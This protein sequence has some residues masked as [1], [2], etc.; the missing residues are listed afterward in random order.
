MRTE[1]AADTFSSD[2]IRR[3]RDIRETYES[4]SQS[5]PKKEDYDEKVG[6][7]NNQNMDFD[8]R[9][10]KG[11]NIIGK[12]RKHPSLL[13]IS[14]LKPNIYITEAEKYKRETRSQAPT[15]MIPAA[16]AILPVPMKLPENK[17]SKYC[18]FFFNDKAIYFQTI[19]A[20]KL[21]MLQYMSKYKNTNFGKGAERSTL[22][23]ERSTMLIERVKSKVKNKSLMCLKCTGA[24][25]GRR[26]L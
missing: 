9:Q 15:S 13:A 16:K 4:A 21:L 19:K 12:Q 20:E 2:Y 3:K 6:N 1:D 18:K 22:L 25:R 23:I 26:L 24:G 10:A 11:R 14:T 17:A 5:E 7:Q 8:I